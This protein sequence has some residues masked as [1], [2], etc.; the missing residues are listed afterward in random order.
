MSTT[1]LRQPTWQVIVGDALKAL[2]AI[3]DKSVHCVV[4]SPP[5]WKVR[6][7]SGKAPLGSELTPEEWAENVAAIYDQVWRVLR[8]DGTNWLNIGDSWYG[9]SNFSGSGEGTDG[10]FN[11][12]HENMG[13][14]AQRRRLPKHDYLK[15]GDLVDQPAI[16]SMA[17]MKRGWYRRHRIVWERTNPLPES[18]KN[19]PAMVHET[20]L[21]LAKR[22]SGYF[23][24]HTAVREEAAEPGKD[25]NRRSVWHIASHPSPVIDGVKHTSTFPLELARLCVAAGSSERGACPDCG[26]PWVRRLSKAKGGSTGKSWHPHENDA[27][28]GNC[29]KTSSKDY[30]PPKTIGWKPSCDC[31][32]RRSPVPALVLDPFSGLA[33]TGE[34]CLKWG[35]DYIGVE[36]DRK[37]AKAS[38][39]R[40]RAFEQS[41]LMPLFAAQESLFGGV[42]DE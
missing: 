32:N 1:A 30:V 35:R 18:A 14:A 41:N 4:S 12:K 20:V 9:A 15:E 3:P 21:L 19:R 33:T 25:R 11:R 31:P 42:E 13:E 23:Y 16:L 26:A 5:Y 39:K 34:V 17:L 38:E 6:K 2:E 29:K 27:V 24:D 8:D 36:K 22:K 28:N 7:Y 40:L 10:V 37:I